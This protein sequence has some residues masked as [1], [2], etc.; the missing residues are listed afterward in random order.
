MALTGGAAGEVPQ[1]GAR[2]ER[3]KGIQANLEKRKRW[4]DVLQRILNIIA[5]GTC[6][7]S[8]RYFQSF[9]TS[10]MPYSVLDLGANFGLTSVGDSLAVFISLRAVT[11]KDFADHFSV[12]ITIQINIIHLEIVLFLFIHFYPPIDTS[13]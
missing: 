13:T 5:S 6:W 11:K 7:K 12:S 4:E 8:Q 1:S 10:G 9:L 2:K 3:G